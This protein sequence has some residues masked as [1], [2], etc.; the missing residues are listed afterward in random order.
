MLALVVELKGGN[1]SLSEGLLNV[2]NVGGKE[3][4]DIEIPKGSEAFSQLKES[5]FTLRNIAPNKIAQDGD[6]ISVLLPSNPI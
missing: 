2:R 1:D 4:Y 6:E 3:G 5:K